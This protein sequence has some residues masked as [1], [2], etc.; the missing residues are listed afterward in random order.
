MLAIAGAKG[1]CGKTVTTLGLAEA[2]ARTGTPA[3]AIDADRQ[4]P[5]AHVSG[6]VDREPTL[7]ALSDENGIRSI[8][9][10]SPRT[11][12]A[13]IVPAPGP[14]EKLDYEA[15]LG[16]LETGAIQTLV[17]CPSGAGPDV[18]EPLSAADGVI[19]VTTDGDRSLTA[20]ETTV[21]MARRLGVRVLGTVLNGCETVPSTVE[22][23]VDVPV[24]G[25]I[26]EAESESPLTDD[27]TTSA[28]EEIVEVLQTRNATNRTPPAYDDDLLATGIGPL[29]RRLGGGLA[30]G[31]VVA[32]TA[33]PASQ[34]EQLLYETTAPRGTLY[35]STQRSAANV[36]RALEIASVETGNPTIRQV[37][38]TTVLA[39]AAEIIDKLPEGATLIIDP[40]NG[41]ERRDRS[42]YVSFLNELKDRMV[43]T[44]SIA[45]LHGLCG[46]DRPANRAATIH[47]TDAVFDVRTV[48]S[49][50]G[51]GVDHYLS[52]PK[53]RPDCAF[54]E[55]IELVFDEEGP[56]QIVASE[57]DDRANG[58]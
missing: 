48:E 17:D 28:Y 6:G 46:P 15:V 19:V 37:S 34:T 9:Q 25:L 30:P 7:A 33:E 58:R 22:S 47:A 1:G 49:G 43:E 11:P 56:M 3:V 29:D 55:S 16:S 36:R 5:N 14:A 8:A 4:L 35:L 2:F 40:V 41:L 32:L 57:D 20:A 23:W 24:L 44:N 42:A 21:E 54:T 12:D 53:F 27:A 45:L 13:G 39:D 52:V 18:V 38:G 26:P 10:T 31:S 50:D 51:A